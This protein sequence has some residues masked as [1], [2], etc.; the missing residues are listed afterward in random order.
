MPKVKRLVL[1][2]TGGIASGKTTVMSFLVNVGIPTISAD[3][4]AH[5]AIG[6]GTPA[7]R[8]ILK[9]F[10]PG[11]LRSSGQICR[12]DLG[13]IVFHDPAQRRWLE[14][15]VHPVVIKE[16]KRFARAHRGVVALDIPLLFEARLEKLVDK[17]LVVSCSRARQVERL[18][19]RD[20]LSRREALR[21]IA[22]QMPLSVKRRR[23]DFV[24]RNAGSLSHLRTQ[25]ESFLKKCLTSKTRRV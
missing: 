8:K 20:G 24:I 16:L 22:A 14:K 15:Q 11:I 6:K 1:G 18:H 13:D 9:R 10:G 17:V 12:K 25:T 3:D 4:L 7:Y 21:R 23:A 5:Q 19:R 2:V